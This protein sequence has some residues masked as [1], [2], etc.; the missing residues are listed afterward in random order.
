MQDIKNS[1]QEEIDAAIIAATAGFMAKGYEWDSLHRYSHLDGSLNYYRA[2][3]ININTSKKEIRP[4]RWNGSSFE[5]KEPDFAN[6][7]PLYNLH[8]LKNADTVYW[9]EGEK[10]ADALNE[11]GL[12]ATTSG[13]ATSHDKADFEPLRGKNISIWPDN[14]KA[15][16]DHANAVAASLISIGCTVDRLDLSA[17]GLPDKGDVIDWLAIH[18]QATKDDINGLQWDR[19]LEKSKSKSF[20][21]T[22]RGNATLTR[23]TDVI[24]RPITWLWDQWLAKGKLTIL[25][26]AGGTGKTTLALGLA[27]AITTGSRFPDGSLCKQ[28]GNVLVWSSEDDPDDVLVP[29][30]MAMGADLSRVYFVSGLTEGD[31]KRAFD[32]S[33]DIETLGTQ[34]EQ[35]GGV[36]LLLVDPIVSAVAND[37]NKA[38]DVCRS[39]QPIVDFANQYQC[40]IIGISHLGKGTQGKDPTERILGSQAFSALARM[41]WL[42]VTNKET[43]DRVLVRSKSN[44]SKTDGGFGY[45]V[46]QVEIVGGIAT[47]RV[48]WKDP[49]DGNASEILNEYESID[50]GD[51]KSEL[52]DAERYLLELLESENVP[53]KKVQSDSKNAGFTWATIRRASK[54]IGVKKI[55]SGMDGGWYWSFPRATQNHEDAQIFPKMLTQKNEHLRDKLSTF[56]EK[57]SILEADITPQTIPFWRKS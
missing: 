21:E 17:I 35:I 13:G 26:G 47:S 27:T 57:D 25:G 48:V 37:M 31:Q 53:A 4:L 32:P 34:V 46:E 9:V 45:A 7:K 18:P 54:S 1:S 22:N 24:V 33:T 12:C 28:I 38:N 30:L 56:E 29:R 40:A 42:T 19:D 15:G 2:R 55:K 44:I 50:D 6:K 20:Q 8:S 39:L 36:S 51:E 5:M 3:F 11:L 43:G 41:V 14:D 10:C 52:K 23:A 49:V 16:I